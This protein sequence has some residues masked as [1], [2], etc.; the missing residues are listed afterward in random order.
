[1]SVKVSTLPLSFRLRLNRIDQ[2][3]IDGVACWK[4]GHCANDGARKATRDRRPVHG[5]TYRGTPGESR[6]QD[7]NETVP[8]SS[9]VDGRHG[10]GIDL[11][12][13]VAARSDCARSTKRD[14]DGGVEV[15]GQRSDLRCGLDLGQ[16]KQAA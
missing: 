15:A 1:M 12:Q 10:Q 16:G 6:S 9:C 4:A 7:A 3:P 5:I 8:R 14:D 11:P 2:G 13:H